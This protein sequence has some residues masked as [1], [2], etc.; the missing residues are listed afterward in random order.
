VDID[1]REIGK[2][3]PTEVGI[4]GDVGAVV[5][6]II[7]EL[8]G[9]GLDTA[10]T[11][12]DTVQRIETAK[13]AWDLEVQEKSRLDD[14]PI[15]RIK[16]FQALR[17]VFPRETIY[18]TDEGHVDFPLYFH[19]VRPA[20][21]SGDWRT[22]G[23]GFPMAIGLKLVFPE[24][25]VVAICG[26]G[27]FSMSLQEL[28]TMKCQGAAPIIIVLNNSGYR[29]LRNRLVQFYGETIG[30]DFTLPD[31]PALGRVFGIHGE[32]IAKASEIKP[33]LERSLRSKSGALIDVVIS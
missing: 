15:T 13:R 33:A 9:L 4:V 7:T 19:S 29:G 18:L 22:I 23:F 6:A 21:F 26:D 20:Y 24:K 3:Y 10:K 1:P 2:N 8:K 16:L 31:L 17:E 5:R 14:S 25:Q 12:S 32:R 27:A 11:R 30:T 28:T